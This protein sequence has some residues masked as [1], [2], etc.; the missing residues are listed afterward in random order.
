MLSVQIAFKIIMSFHSK[1]LVNF[2]ILFKLVIFL[3]QCDLSFHSVCGK[4]SLDDTV[5]IFMNFQRNAAYI[6]NYTDKINN[7]VHVSAVCQRHRE[8]G[9][10][11][12]EMPLQYLYIKIL[13]LLYQKFRQV[14]TKEYSNI[15]SCTNSVLITDE[16]LQLPD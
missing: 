14:R 3:R 1:Y 8:Q 6:I 12:F 10:Q 16:L 13:S 11:T 2:I 5:Y 9:T 15:F 7:T 4:A